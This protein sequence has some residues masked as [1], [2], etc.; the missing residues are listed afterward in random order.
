MF[1]TLL[2]FQKSLKN[3]LPWGAITVFL[4][5]PAIQ[6]TMIVRGNTA[7]I[8]QN[9]IALENVVASPSRYTVQLYKSVVKGITI[10]L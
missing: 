8:Y 6:W 1:K 9:Y 4:N 5:N 2:L 10:I 3:G 7:F